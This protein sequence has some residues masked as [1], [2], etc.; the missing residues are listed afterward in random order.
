MNHGWAICQR[1]KGAKNAFTADLHNARGDYCGIPFMRS[2]LLAVHEA[3]IE[4]GILQIDNVDW[5]FLQ[6]SDEVLE[7]MK[8]AL[9]HLTT[10]ELVISTGMD[11]NGNEIGVE[12]PTCRRY[13]SNNTKLAEFLAAAPNLKDLA[14]GF[15][16]YE[17]YCPAEL[18]QVF[19]STSGPC[20]ES[21]ALEN[22]DAASENLNRFLEQ[23]ASML[24]HVI[25]KTVRLLEG[26]WIDTPKNEPDLE[27]E[28][29]VHQRGITWRGSA[30]ALGF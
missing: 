22:I 16:W 25:M 17:P 5:K 2:L 15:D 7:R 26:T 18:R 29:G 1:P 13:H 3:S 28:V 19:G 8:T 24:K 4:L 21:V 9:R 6:Q 12:I 23:H 30:S 11:E 10:L 20:L 14:I 27:F